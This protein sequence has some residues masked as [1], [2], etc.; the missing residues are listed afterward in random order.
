MNQQQNSASPALQRPSYTTGTSTTPSKAQEA[1]FLHMQ[2]RKMQRDINGTQKKSNSIHLVALVVLLGILYGVGATYFQN[3]QFTTT[4]TINLWQLVL[5][6]IWFV[7]CVIITSLFSDR[8]FIGLIFWMVIYWPL[9]AI[10]V[11]LIFS[12]R[13]EPKRGGRVNEVVLVFFVIAEVLTFLVFVVWH[14]LRP[15][16]LRSAWFRQNVGW[17]YRVRVVSDWTMMYD[18]RFRRRHTCKYQGDFAAADQ[19]SS[20][21]PSGF[22]KLDG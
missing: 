3:G 6:G 2:L 12:G 11:S 20:L 15:T 14:F 9:L 4:V 22:G 16:I 7:L 17:C 19:N 1:V 10:L 13:L 5:I 18:G 8:H 21:M